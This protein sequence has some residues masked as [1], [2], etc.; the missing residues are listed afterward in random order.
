M[1]STMA[2]KILARASGVQSV[3]TGDAVLAKISFMTCLDGQT[4]I[5]KFRERNLKV[6]DPERMIFCFDHIFQPDWM[7][8]QAL[9]EHPKIK[10]FAKEQGIPQENIYDLGRNGISHQI[11]VEHGWALP[12]DV[13][14]GADTQSATMGAVNCFALPALFGVDPIIVSGAIWMIVPEC[15]RIT[16]TG[17]LPDGVNGKDIVYRFIADL[18]KVAQGRVIEFDGPGVASLPMDMRLAVANGSVQ[19]GALT[20]IFPADQT[21][22]DYVTPRARGPFQPVTP[23][24]D[25]DY[26]AHYE[27]DLGSITPLVAGP[28][29]ID[30]IRDLDAVTGLPITA[31]YIGSCSS[32]RLSDLAL[33]AKV[34][35]G[36]KVHPS[37]RL[38]VTPISAE[39]HREANRAGI[40]QD[41]L[42]AGATVTQPGCGACYSGNLSPLKLADGERC[43]STSV[44]TLR[45]RMGSPES[46]VMLANAAVVAASA[47]TGKITNPATISMHEEIPA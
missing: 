17:E 16:L 44:E 30:L 43:I 6:W 4:F 9:S 37:V 46:E 5:D 25:A 2:A 20:I 3:A 42:D 13:C 39:T 40:L 26:V 29:N 27:Y 22:L 47:I 15:V 21:M 35:R 28:H 34:L 32:G 38:V 23:D 11:P 19:I 24:A 31:A 12:G 1:G 18:G 8:V 10:S 45:G 41:L 7:A 14:I 36:H 33:A